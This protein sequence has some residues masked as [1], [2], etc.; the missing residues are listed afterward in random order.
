[1]TAATMRRQAD[2]SAPARALLLAS[3]ITVCAASTYALARAALGFAPTPPAA[4]EIAVVVHLA[5]VMPAM[6]LGLYLFVSRK[7]GTRH[8]LLGR[9]WMLLM[10]ITAVSALFIRHLNEGQL[11]PVHIASVVTLAGI[12]FAI[13]AARSGRI[14]AHRGHLIRMYI[15]AL[16]VS[17]VLSFLPGRIMWNWMFG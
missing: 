7:G 15:G 2:L 17:G 8:K 1:M 4:K 5:T 16:L 12:P 11:S 13:Q 3:G 14:D 6:P 10:A 9:I